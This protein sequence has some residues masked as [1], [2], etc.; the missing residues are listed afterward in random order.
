M[1]IVGC[2]LP[3]LLKAQVVANFSAN[4]TSG[5]SPLTV[6]FTNLSTGNPTNYSWTFGNSNT[7]VLQNPSATYVVPGTY[8]VSLTASNATFSDVETKTAFITVF[9]NPVAQFT[10]TPLSGCAPLGVAFNSSTSTS[11]APITGWTWDL[12]NGNTSN[13]QNPTNTYANIGLYNV[14]LLVRDANGCENS[15]NKPNYINVSAPF[16]ASIGAIGPTQ[17]CQAPFTVNFRKIVPQNGSYT[18]VWKFGDNTIST[19]SNP[20]KT[21]TANGIYD[22]ELEVT[23][24]N[25]CKQ[26]V[27]Q[28]GLVR[29]GGV[30]ANFNLTTDADC[31]PASL[32]A[33][34][35]STPST[36][37]QYEWYLNNSPNPV[38]R[39]P[40]FVTALS[41][42]NGT[43]KLIVR[44]AAGCSDSIEKTIQ[45]Q[46]PPVADFDMSDSVFCKPPATVNFTNKS[47]PDAV[48][49][50]WNF[51]N[52]IGSSQENPSITYSTPRTYQV[53]LI[54]TRPRG[55]SATKTR[56]V[57]VDN[58][59]A[60]IIDQNSKSGCPP[61]STPIGAIDRSIL[62]LKNIKWELG[63]NTI[64]TQFNF[65]YTFTNTGTYVLRF[66]AE[67]LPG[68]SIVLFD[69]IKVIELPKFDIVPERTFQCYNPGTIKFFYV[70]LNSIKPTIINW[71]FENPNGVITENG[72][73]V[74]VKFRDTGYYKLTLYVANL[75]CDTT[76]IKENYIYI[77]PPI[78]RYTFTLDS[79]NSDS[80]VFRNQSVGKNRLTWYFG[81]GTEAYNTGQITKYYTNSGSYTVKL[82][83]E[84]TLSGCKDTTS[85]VLLINAKPNV[86]FS[87][88]DTAVCANSV[89]KF[90]DRT[91]VQAPRFIKS[92][93]YSLTNGS[94]STAQNPQFVFPNQ[95]TVGVQLS[96]VDDKNCQYK[97]YDTITVKVFS[98]RPKFTVTPDRGCVPLTVSVNDTSNM[99][100]PTV[101]RVW[102]WTNND[103]T[104]TNVRTAS[105]TYLLAAPNQE[106]GLNIRLDVIDSKGCRFSGYEVVRPF[107][108]SA[109]FLNQSHKS[110][111]TDSITLT[112]TLSAATVNRPATFI[113]NLP[114]GISTREISFFTFAQDNDSILPVFLQLRDSMGCVDT[115]TKWVNVDARKP[116]IGF[117]ATPRI[118][119]CYKSQKNPIIFFDTTIIGASNVK[120]RTWTFGN[121]NTAIRVGDTARTVSA[122]Y[123]K[124]GKYPVTLNITDGLN[125][126]D[127]LGIADFIVAG[128]PNGNYSFTPGI[129]CN[130]TEIFF[131]VNSPN[132]AL[133]IWDHADGNVD[134]FTVDS[135]SYTYTREGIYYP[136][137]TLVDSTLTCDYGLDAID[138]IVILPLPK[139]DFTTTQQLVCKGNIGNLVNTTPNH[140]SPIRSW[141]WV[142]GTKDSTNAFT[143]PPI[144]FDTAGILNISLSATDTNGC[145]GMIEKDS[146][147]IVIDDS[148][149]PAIPLIK[150]AT[151]VDDVSVQLNTLPNSE[152]DFKEYIIYSSTSQYTK[153]NRLDTI[154]VETGLN[155]LTTTYQYQMQAIDICLNLSEWSEPHRTVNVTASPAINAIDVSWTPYLG[156]DTSFHYEVWRKSPTDADYQLLKSVSRDTL[157]I[158]DTSILCYQPYLYRIKAIED[159]SL[160]SYSWSDTSGASAFYVSALPV[161]RNIRATVENN[162]FVRLEWH[163]EKHN[164]Y[165]RYE[166]YRSIDNGN[167]TPF[168]ILE[169]TD[170][171]LIDEE[172]NVQEHTYTYYT[173]L[174]D[175]C[176]GQSLPSNPARTILLSVRMVGNDILKH[177]PKLSW[178]AYWLWENGVDHYQVD[179]KNEASNTFELIARNDSTN[180]IAQHQYINLVQAE[181]CYL[182]TAYQAKDTNVFSQSNITCV[183]TEP[184]LYAPNVFTINNDN[185]NDRF[186]VRGIFVESFTLSI[187]NR[188]GEL[189][190]QSNDMNEGWDGTFKGEEC[191]PD[192]FVYLA[193]G[194]GRKGQ[195]ATITGNVTLIR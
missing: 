7:S 106:T 48:Q 54:A 59:A 66:S 133:Y 138:S 30:K 154:F 111:G 168:K 99:E 98:G 61:F 182:V 17:A 195:R 142:I 184:R 13:L 127:S 167:P 33:V 163:Q 25:G 9:A 29:I 112:P 134:S 160:R 22:V 117:H 50:N 75:G 147:F 95:G 161:A 162:R 172:V 41:Q 92:W 60:T 44:N 73:T 110:C 159:D 52:M 28:V 62:G 46:D 90:T 16:T 27:K 155:T 18:Y 14:T 177:D 34:N 47:S 183:S 108:P 32:S 132:S 146:F 4:R 144:L 173:Y 152:V 36:G 67:T 178:N 83:V 185:L 40:G 143:P 140:T 120:S 158:Q 15:I 80:A 71:R 6:Q 148:I 20:S 139:P 58:P 186:Y 70:P 189:V 77:S 65:N 64:S 194:I 156:F 1:I 114:Q 122:F 126:K 19:D 113:W 85:K 38:G 125:C 171:V 181:Y 107:K 63:G 175:S 129:G 137:I 11:P 10:G 2:I 149:P 150:N 69:T 74:S 118:I 56:T 151:V 128:G 103:S 84:D 76:I 91:T 23:S 88:T 188:W 57:I 119:P 141:K 136:R 123:P 87:P 180:L 192:V 104:V 21:Y 8:T 101:S 157:A 193:E 94:T 169:S 115:I 170:T 124:P 31:L 179:F 109:N 53:R 26:V 39:N 5:C 187:Y 130:P 78:A 89:V 100:N 191:K 174:S 153:P 176:G 116:K 24:A 135:H 105:S 190:Y 72:D 79:C 49:F 42:K 45:L 164:R 68:C 166:I 55:C 37:L 145:T 97:Y 3:G 93:F 35:A 102:Y 51:G 131:K 86:M 165:F 81:D 12:G 82:V 121:G 43:L 96:V